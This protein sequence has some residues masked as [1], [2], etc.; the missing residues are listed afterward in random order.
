LQ[1]KLDYIGTLMVIFSSLALTQQLQ[2]ESSVDTARSICELS[3]EGG[4]D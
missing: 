3:C 4:G 2:M 1:I